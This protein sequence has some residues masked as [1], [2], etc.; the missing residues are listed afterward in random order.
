MT[1]KKISYIFFVLIVIFGWNALIIQRD[2]K[3]FEGYDS[4]KAT[5]QRCSQ[6][7]TFHP[8]CNP[9]P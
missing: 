8:N 1:S 7:K 6:F 9:K 5:E 4:M 3:M 2:K